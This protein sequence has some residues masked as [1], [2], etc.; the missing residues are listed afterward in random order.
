MKRLGF[1]GVVTLAFLTSTSAM[2]QSAG[3][4]AEFPPASFTGN[5]YVDSNGCA[6]IRAGFSGR[7]TWVPRIDRRS[8]QL[9]NFQP[10]F[11][12]GSQ[13][14]PAAAAP[15]VQAPRVAPLD[16]P[17]IEITA[18]PPQPRRPLAGVLDA[19]IQTVAS[20]PAAV[21]PSPQ[22]I[23]APITI[24]AP[25]PVAAPAAPR[26][27]LA[28][29][30]EGRFGVQT[31]FV[32]S[33]T[34]NPVDCGPAPQV[35]PTPQ[36]APVA[37]QP[38]VSAPQ[39]RR[40]TLAQACAG[41]FG[42]Q[43]GFISS[44]T[45]DPIDCGPAPQIATAT[46]APAPVS[47]PEPRRITLAQA[48]A[49]IG[50]TGLRYI[51]ART[52]DPIV[53]P[54]ATTPTVQAA[55]PAARTSGSAG[56]FLQRRTPPVSNPVITRRETIEVPSGYVR[57]WG[58][59]RLNAQRGLPAAAPVAKATIAPAQDRVSTRTAPQSAT[60]GSHRYVQVGSFGDHAN[61]DRLIQRLGAAGLPVGAGSS[62][63]MKIVAVGPFANQADLQNALQTVR[64]MGFGDAYTRN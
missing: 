54:Q 27:T 33:R 64:G 50:T 41:R 23:Q 15:Q 25:Q 62:G 29:A 4:P 14:G 26:I 10:T 3:L 51:N 39:P 47:A 44:R 42:I 34:G 6:F 20:I 57:V 48:C 12:A 9:C 30:C 38:V 2:A 61:A 49:E 63:A 11:A 1:A 28:Q 18:P 8:T 43:P 17:I 40:I 36:A 52:G 13:P 21:A 59:G 53:C 31:G 19:P 58:D 5:Q 60:G 55:A 16:A 46:T 35:A 22:V 37:A 7:V 45:G 24:P 32:N 56:Y